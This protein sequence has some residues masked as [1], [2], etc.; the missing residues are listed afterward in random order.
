[1][2]KIYAFQFNIIK[3]CYYLQ[4]LVKYFMLREDLM[5]FSHNVV[6]EKK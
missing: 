6:Y 3:N 4:Y 5:G 2:Y 1:M